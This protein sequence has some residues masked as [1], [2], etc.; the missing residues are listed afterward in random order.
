[1]NDATESHQR[2]GPLTGLRVLDLTRILAGPTCTQLLGDLGADIVKIERPGVGD[3][4]RA[5]GPPFLGRAD[6]AESRES[7]YFLSSNRNKRS[8]AVDMAN[9]AGAAV[10]RALALKADV[11]VENFKVGGLAKYGLGYA[12]LAVDAPRLVYCSITGFGQTGPNAHRAGYDLLAQADAGIMALTGEPDGA[13]MKVGVGIA[14]VVCGLYA[15]N[16]VQ[17][18]LL[19]RETT[20]RGQHIDLSL[21]D[22]TLAWL[23][24]EGVNARVSGQEPVRRGN[25]HP[26]IAPY[27]V[28]EA[29]D[30]HFIVAAGNDGQ[31]QKLCALL[32]APALAEDPR[33]RTNPDRLAHRDALVAALSP[34]IAARPRTDLAE[35]MD[36]AG[37]PGGAIRSVREA[38]GS[39]QARARGMT[40]DLPDPQAAGGVAPVLGNPIKF[41]ETPI[42]HRRPPPRLGEHT[43]ATLEELIGAEALAAARAAGALG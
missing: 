2:A 3:D 13:P 31:F 5:W 6:G 30:G 41:S 26:N 16:A 17:A 43:D 9:P 37:V 11:L 15:A 28:F 21:V 23:I 27:Q 38:L 35:A 29:A 10:V 34:L 42:A 7:A 20:G 32:G 39:E 40:L 24:N 12:D 36:A 1:M 22:S 33:F 8:V 25:A 14:D 19:A 4:T 18:A